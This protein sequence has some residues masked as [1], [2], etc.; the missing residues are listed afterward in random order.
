MHGKVVVQ[1]SQLVLVLYKIV[2]FGAHCM[3]NLNLKF[4]ARN[5]IPFFFKS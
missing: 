3:K 1:A 2:L 5:E 4:H